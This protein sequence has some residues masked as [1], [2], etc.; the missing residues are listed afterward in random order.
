MSSSYKTESPPNLGPVR[1]R[2]RA[3]RKTEEEKKKR[4]KIR[5]E[6]REE[7]RKTKGSDTEELQVA[8][9]NL[10]GVSLREITEIA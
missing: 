2:W 4:K 3:G 1:R 5:E 7:E 6:K 8:T 9:W 10:Q